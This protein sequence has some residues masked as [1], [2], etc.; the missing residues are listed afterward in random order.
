[1]STE[2][3]TAQETEMGFTAEDFFDLSLFHYADLY[4][5]IEYIWEAIAKIAGYVE[6]KLAE[7]GPRNLGTTLG[8][9]YIADNV[10]IGEGTVVEHGAVIKGPAV[11]GANCEIRNGA[12]VRGN[13][14]CDDNTVLGNSCEVKNAAIHQNGTVPHFAYVGDSI[15]GFKAHLGAGVKISNV[16]LTWETV[17]VNVNGTV[18][19]TGLKKFGAILGDNTDIGCNSVLNPGSIIGKRSIVYPNCSWRG[20]LP[21]NR[22]AKMRQTVEV[23]VREER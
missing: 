8:S 20:I 9:P 17:K 15:L 14:I 5:G 1:M 4:D 11:I 12:Y 21:A 19:D 22:I 10:Y 16:K 2:S 6:A 13:F 18:V 23:V 7:L 3:A